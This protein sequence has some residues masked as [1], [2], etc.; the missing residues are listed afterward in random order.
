MTTF[1]KITGIVAISALALTG[2][3]SCKKEK[4]NTNSLNAPSDQTATSKE[5]ESNSLEKK[6]V[7]HYGIRSNEG[8]PSAGQ[9]SMGIFELTN[10]TGYQLPVITNYFGYTA[11]S[12]YPN[13]TAGFA[14]NGNQ[15]VFAYKT[16]TNEVIMSYFG[17]ENVVLNPNGTLFYTTIEEIEIDPATGLLYGLCKPSGISAGM[18]IYRFD[19]NNDG[20]STAVLLMNGSTPTIFNSVFSNGYKS[21]SI[22]FYP[23]GDGTNRLVFTNES[24]VYGS[25]G[26]RM[27]NYNIVGNNL[28]PLPLLS[29]SFNTAST[30][31]PGALTGKINTAYGNGKFY[32]ARD[33]GNLYTIDL[34]KPSND[35]TATV[36]FTTTP[37]QNK[38]DFGFYEHF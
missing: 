14:S 22:C 34:T 29:K 9:T 11:G 4:F 18:R 26:I 10:T 12:V 20:T 8:Y 17:S 23:N 27:W 2:V 6:P 7:Y 37:I 38:N 32:F 15:S 13:V 24:T 21:G 36:Q 25:L 31:I 5:D 28:I 3:T 35:P 33:N 30:G 19:N 1:K 16:A